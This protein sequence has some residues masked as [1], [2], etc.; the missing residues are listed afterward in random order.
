MRPVRKADNFATT[1][2]RCHVIWE[3]YIPGTL[4]TTPGPNGTDLPLPLIC[5]KDPSDEKSEI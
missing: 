4:W 2:C 1:L 3:P 5:L